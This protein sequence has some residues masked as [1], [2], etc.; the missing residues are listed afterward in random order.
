MCL[1]WEVFSAGG[2]SPPRT[3]GVWGRRNVL[4]SSP[5]LQGNELELPLVSQGCWLSCCLDFFIA[6]S[7][8]RGCLGPADQGHLINYLI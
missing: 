3:A 1:E 8:F 4:V 7:S 5:F 2:L 6:S